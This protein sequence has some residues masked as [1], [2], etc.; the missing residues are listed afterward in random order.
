MT[1]NEFQHIPEQG[2][3]FA[4]IAN[5]LED[6]QVIAKFYQLDGH[7]AYPLYL[8]TDF[9]SQKQQGPWFLPYPN[10]EFLNYF[11]QHASGFIIRFDD[12]IETQIPHW[13][14]LILA[15]LDGDTVLFRYYDRHALAP[16]L[17]SF[18][19]HELS[20]FLGTATSIWLTDVE[21]KPTYFINPEPKSSM[22]SSPWW[23]I[24]PHHTPYS[25][26]THAWILERL[27]WQRLPTLMKQLVV[28]DI[29]ISKRLETELLQAKSLG[30]TDE[31]QEV[32]SLNQLAKQ[33]D[34]PEQEMIEAWLLDVEQV[35][36]LTA[37]E[38]QLAMINKG[39]MV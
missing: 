8:N 9:A 2:K 23:R 32:F 35:T 28:S 33:I 16:M 10:D 36:Q 22:Q 17:D 7:D 39:V 4:I 37:A 5:P 24:K 29:D 25:A 15:G 27:S 6:E 14:S 34:W 1:F 30:L 18:E 3:H 20:A 26:I 21:D 38:K 19:A 13:Q 12:N 11:S 31:V